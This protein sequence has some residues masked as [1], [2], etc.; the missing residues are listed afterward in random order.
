MLAI[1]I[2][3]A[4]IRALTPEEQNLFVTFANAA[5]ELAALARIV[6]I[7]GHQE[8][9]GD[10]YE[11]F[12][13]S[14]HLTMLKLYAGKVYEGWQ[15]IRQR[16]F[17]SKLSQK[18]DAQL[19]PEAK[20]DL[21]TLKR[22]FASG[23]TVIALL[24]NEGAFHYSRA[25][26]K[27]VLE[28]MD[29]AYIYLAGRFYCNELYDFGDQ[30][31]TRHL[32]GQ[33]TQ[34]PRDAVSI[35]NDD[36][37]AVG[38]MVHFFMKALLL[39]MIERAALQDAPKCIFMQFKMPK[40]RKQKTAAIPIFFDPSEYRG[41]FVRFRKALRGKLKRGRKAL[42]PID[43]AYT[44]MKHLRAL[45]KAYKGKRLPQLKTSD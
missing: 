44:N 3:A 34:R 9:P 18:Y 25:D 19:T 31:M 15:L 10:V 6:T 24:R 30:V 5:N 37:A 39:M 12:V 14:Q 13:D 45:S 38:M 4:N 26:I 17:G 43:K 2:P 20:R 40:Q 21:D 1:R 8:H 27:H 28:D 23:K 33:I 42:R 22:Y 29:F 35:V 36:I 7:C 32:F 16:Y 11:A 41:D